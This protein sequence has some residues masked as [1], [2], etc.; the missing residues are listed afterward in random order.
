MKKKKDVCK[1]CGE[2]VKPRKG[3]VVFLVEGKKIHTFKLSERTKDGGYR[4]ELIGLEKEPKSVRQ[5]LAKQIVDSMGDS[6]REQAV[7]AVE[8]SLSYQDADEL[9]DIKRDIDKG[10]PP[11]L[12]S[13]GKPGCLFIKHSHGK[14]Y[15]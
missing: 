8:K 10:K 12:K 1:S 3:N 4:L 5:A 7:E 15:L 2:Q 11:V 13:T 9:R 14:T 6:L